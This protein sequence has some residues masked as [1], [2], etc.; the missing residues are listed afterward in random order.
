MKPPRE[1]SV[2]KTSEVVSI[3]GVPTKTLRHWEKQFG[4]LQGHHKPSR[5]DTPCHYYYRPLQVKKL[6]LIKHLAFDQGL[7]V[8]QIQCIIHPKRTT[9]DSYGS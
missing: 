7:S 4:L 1:R 8:D 2:Y 5:R 6:L 9:E 3:L